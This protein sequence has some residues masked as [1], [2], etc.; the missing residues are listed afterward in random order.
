[1]LFRRHS[2]SHLKSAPQMQRPVAAYPWDV[3]MVLYHPK[4]GSL[5]L[6][7][8]YM[9]MLT[10]SLH[11]W[12]PSQLW[13]YKTLKTLASHPTSWLFWPTCAPTPEIISIPE[14]HV[15]IRSGS[16]K[17]PFLVVAEASLYL[18]K[19]LVPIPSSTRMRQSTNKLKVKTLKR[20]S[21]L[22]VEDV[23]LVFGQ[24]KA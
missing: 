1:M 19:C 7:L 9:P 5:I 17:G 18:V 20:Y 14:C 8:T 23:S 22:V 21:V 11:C 10:T 15:R 2:K 13:T 16:M 12:T 24:Y 6:R 4:L 3:K